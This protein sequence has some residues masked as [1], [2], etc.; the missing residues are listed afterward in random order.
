MDEEVASVE[1][2]VELEYE[3]V[4]QTSFHV[5]H[6]DWDADSLCEQVAALFSSHT[7]HQQLC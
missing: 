1:V 2:E 4:C 6:R 3:V 7:D 5:A